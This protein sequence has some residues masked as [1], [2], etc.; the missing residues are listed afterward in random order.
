MIDDRSLD[1]STYIHL[2]SRH[3]LGFVCVHT[4]R[5][6]ILFIFIHRYL[7]A[8]PLIVH[9]PVRTSFFQRLHVPLVGA[10]VT[11]REGFL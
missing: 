2:L 1:F 8:P 6:A 7:R 10:S 5:Y 11:M 9:R 3:E 4:H